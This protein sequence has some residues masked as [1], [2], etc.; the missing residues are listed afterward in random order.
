LRA[1]AQL[2]LIFGEFVVDGQII[3][4]RIASAIRRH[5]DDMD[6]DAGPFDVTQELKSESDPHR[7][8][9]D[10]ARH[11]GHDETAEAFDIDDAQIGDEGCERISADFGL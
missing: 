7:C 10:D 6:D 5:I 3:V 1:L 8:P 2:E 9:F 11:I 4:I